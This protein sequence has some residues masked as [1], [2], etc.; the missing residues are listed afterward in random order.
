M[1]TDEPPGGFAVTGSTLRP[2]ANTTMSTLPETNSGTVDSDRP[3]ALMSRSVARPRCRAAVTPPAMLSG[4][5][6]T[7]A[8]A[9]SLSE[10]PIAGTRKE[11]TGPRYW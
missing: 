1:K 2:I 9:A 10:R 3:V 4:T 5:T 11:L 8:T 7:K 6:M